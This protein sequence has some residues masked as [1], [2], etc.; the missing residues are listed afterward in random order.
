MDGQL[1]FVS[2]EDLLWDI[3]SEIDHEQKLQLE[4]VDFMAGYSANLGIICVV[5]IDVIIEL[6]S[7][8]NAGDQQSVDVEGRNHKG[9]VALDDR[10]HIYESDDVA[11]AAASCIAFYPLEVLPEAN[12]RW[13]DSVKDSHIGRRPCRILLQHL[14]V[15]SDHLGQNACD[16]GHDVPIAFH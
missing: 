13:L 16:N 4:V 8:H 11:F 6:G 3:K 5:V 14:V 15:A 10:I 2:I 1:V 12:G 7:Q 9:F